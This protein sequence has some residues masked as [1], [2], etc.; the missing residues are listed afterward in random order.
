MKTNQLVVRDEDVLMADREI[1][2]DLSA[3]DGCVLFLE[4]SEDMP[5]AA[6]VYGILRAMGERGLLHRFPALL[7]GRYD[8][9]SLIGA[10]RVRKLLSA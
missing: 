5:S 7:M 1:Q 3:Y 6:D 10:D 9:R 4:T 2:R 8:L